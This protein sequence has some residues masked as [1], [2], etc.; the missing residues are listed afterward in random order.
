MN[1]YYTPSGYLGWVEYRWREF[2]T[3]AAYL[4]YMESKI[5]EERE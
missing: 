2:E 4:E 5:E 1:G 3:E